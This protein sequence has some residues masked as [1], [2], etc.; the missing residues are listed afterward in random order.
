MIQS[1]KPNYEQFERAVDRAEQMGSIRNSITKGDGN[2]AGFVSEEVVADLLDATKA[3]TKDYDL[4]LSNGA[5]VDVKAK[6]TSAAPLPYYDCSVAKTSTHQ[7]CDLYVFTRYHING[8]LYVL[9]WLTADD[10][11]SK[12]R[13]L[14]KGTTDG[15]NGFVVRADCY[16]VRIDELN[17]FEE[18]Y[19]WTT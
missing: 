17:D 10:Y 2:L 16:N 3:S 11:F 14:K 13:F 5:T 12:A 15:D 9:G 1:F 8:T 19:T 6:R 4:V 18:L 7:N